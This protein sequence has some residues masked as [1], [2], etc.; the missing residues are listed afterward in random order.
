M[1]FLSPIA[2]VNCYRNIHENIWFTYCRDRELRLRWR[3]MK[4]QYNCYQI[5]ICYCHT[6]L[7]I[8]YHTYFGSSYTQKISLMN[9]RLCKLPLFS[10][11]LSSCTQN[12]ILKEKCLTGAN[13]VFVQ[14]G[15]GLGSLWST[16]A[17]RGVRFTDP[18]CQVDSVYV[19]CR[20]S[21]R[22]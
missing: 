6:I 10:K 18:P 9:W 11:L 17:T 4:M 22:P 20:I 19:I 2:T 5:W 7:R 21:G 3:K 14:V 1:L 15:G 12:P 16:R 8:S 13:F